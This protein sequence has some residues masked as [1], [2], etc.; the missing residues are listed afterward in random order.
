MEGQLCSLKV[1]REPLS[2]NLGCAYIKIVLSSMKAIVNPNAQAESF[3]YP[4][5]L[6]M[7]RRRLSLYFLH[8]SLNS[9]LDLSR[10]FLFKK[11]FKEL[12]F[13]SRNV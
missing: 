6:I 5:S 8:I 7:N 11:D 1:W 2:Y 13:V 4:S 9:T 3:W 12:G 10:T